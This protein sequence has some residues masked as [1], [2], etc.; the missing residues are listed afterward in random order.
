MSAFSGAA[1]LSVELIEAFHKRYPHCKVSQGYGMTETS[2]GAIQCRDEDVE[3][4]HRGVG[5]L[6]PGYE[7]RLV[8]EDGR[9]AH[10]GERGELWLR[11]PSVMKGY[12]NNREATAKTMAP[13]NWLK[14]G[15]VAVVDK[16][17]R[18]A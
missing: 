18:F 16:D 9:D 13:G 2:P 15:D 12:H 11:G 3:A 10:P 14:T 7:A 1:P 5:I 17:H 6:C 4:G 8:M